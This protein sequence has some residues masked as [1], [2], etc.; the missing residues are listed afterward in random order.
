[1]LPTLYRVRIQLE[2]IPAGTRLTQAEECEV[3]PEMLEGLP[4][5]LRAERA[6]RFVEMLSFFH[7]KLARETY[8]VIFRERAESLRLSIQRELRVWLEAIKAQVESSH[9]PILSRPG[10]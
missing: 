8:A 5:S 3:T 10:R 1:M 9:P 2:P 7:P 6:W 4:V